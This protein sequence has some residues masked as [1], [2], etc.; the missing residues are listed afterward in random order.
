[1]AWKVELSATA[2]RELSKFDSQQSKRILKSL[3]ER[4]AKLDNP[5]SMEKRCKVR[6][7]GNFGSIAWRLPAHLQDRR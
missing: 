3:R 2:E 4:I 6:V 1:M 7:S 5:R